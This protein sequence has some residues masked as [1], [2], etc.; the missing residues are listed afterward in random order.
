MTTPAVT[1]RPALPKD[2]AAFLEMWRDFVSLAPDEP[3][4]P[5][6]GERNWDRVADAASGLRCIVA[7]DAD[8]VPQGFTLF[9]TFP[10]TWSKG[11]ACYLQ[12]IFVKAENRGS[13]AARAMIS[14]LE[15]LGREAGWFKIFWMTQPDNFTAQRLYDKVAQRMDYLRYDLNVSEP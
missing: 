12:D 3:G 11:D 1:I 13:G 5:Q 14:H 8:D 7:V 15:Q 4:N 6:M 2:R 10:F 9:L